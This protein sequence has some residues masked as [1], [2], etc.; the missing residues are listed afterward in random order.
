MKDVIKLLGGSVIPL[1]MFP[2][3]LSGTASLFPFWILFQLPQSMLAG[4]AAL[5]ELGKPI[6]ML[7]C[8][9][10]GADCNCLSLMEI[11]SEADHQTGRLNMRMIKL[12]FLHIKYAVKSGMQFKTNFIMAWSS[13]ILSYLIIYLQAFILT[14]NYPVIGGWSYPEIVLL[15]AMQFFSYSI[16]NTLFYGILHNMDQYI[17]NGDLDRMMVRPVHRSSASCGNS[18]TG[19]VSARFSFTRFL[20]YSLSVNEIRWSWGE[21][22]LFFLCLVERSCCSAVFY[23]LW[24]DGIWLKRSASLSQMLYF[25]FAVFSNYPINIYNRTIR[26]ILST[27]LPWAYV[28]FIRQRC[29]WRKRL[30]WKQLYLLTPVIGAAAFLLGILLMRRGAVPM[31]A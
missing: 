17:N 4:T 6:C 25:N 16:A 27:V 10:R 7:F 20:I 1:W 15:M 19:P 24:R 30:A 11:G 22:A 14:R 18:L 3:F 21:G 8:V 29:F 12:Y 9:D 5:D 31:K 23:R 28:N 13:N 26:V 2:G